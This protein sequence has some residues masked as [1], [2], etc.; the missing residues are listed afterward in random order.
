M[1]LY[2]KAVD[3]VADVCEHKLL[4]ILLSHNTVCENDFFG[5]AG[6]RRTL[7]LLASHHLRKY[8]R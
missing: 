6:E 4:A 2:L 7:E 5:L 3:T 8:A 1:I